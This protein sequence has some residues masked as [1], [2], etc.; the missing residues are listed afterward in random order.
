MEVGSRLKE[1]KDRKFS[2]FEIIKI[3]GIGTF[4][5]VFLA[6]LDGRPVAI[7]QMKKKHILELQ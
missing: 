4:G 1:N 7:K 2:D 3:I 5:K 6:T